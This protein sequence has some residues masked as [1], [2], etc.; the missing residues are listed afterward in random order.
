MRLRYFVFTVASMLI[1]APAF[2]QVPSGSG[3][4]LATEKSKASVP[5]RTIDG[6]PDLQGVWSFANLTPLE[7]PAE[8]GT[9]AYLTDQEAAAYAKRIRDGRN[10]DRRDGGAAADVARA[11]NDSWWDFG[12]RAS[13]Q[14]SLIIDPPDGK[15]PALTEEGK[16]RAEARRA[17]ASRPAQGPE[18]RSLGERCILGFNSGPPMLPSAYN[19]NVQI[20]QTKDTVVLLNE[21]VHNARVIPLDGRPHGTVRQWVGDSRGHWEGDTLVVDTINFTNEGTTFRMPVD[22]N[23]HLIERFTRRDANTLIYEF[24]VDDPTIVTKPWTARVPM[25]KSDEPMYEYACHEGNYG[26]FGILK[27]ARAEEKAAEAAAKSNS[28]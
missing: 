25:A 14:T 4:A 12:N 24:T 27:G 13:N 3:I 8:F 18:D 2:A 7:R 1:A 22:Q 19:N 28:K 21:M 15:L 10:M 9:K 23:F 17:A 6:Q 20:F 5:P 16:K 11:Y 26:M